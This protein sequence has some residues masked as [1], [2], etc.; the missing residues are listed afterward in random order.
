MAVSSRIYHWIDERELYLTGGYYPI[1]ICDILRSPRTSYLV[2]HKLGFDSYY[3][4]V[5]LAQD[6]QTSRLVSLKIL[7]ADSDPAN[8]SN[9]SAF[10]AHLVV[11]AAPSSERPAGGPASEHP[12]TQYMFHSV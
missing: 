7:T 8:G 1:T 10:L 6:M 11:D 3:S 5:W 4:I 12:A 9:E 2:L